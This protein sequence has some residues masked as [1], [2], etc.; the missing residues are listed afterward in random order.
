MRVT[1]WIF[2]IIHSQEIPKALLK[3]KLKALG[4]LNLKILS[5][6]S[7]LKVDEWLRSSIRHIL[8]LGY[9][10]ICESYTYN[11]FSH[12]KFKSVPS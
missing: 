4:F 9:Q 11:K 1:L 12:Q 2:N 3:S 6:L 5:I 10:S 8:F 7:G